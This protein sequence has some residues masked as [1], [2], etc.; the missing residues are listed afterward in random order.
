MNVLD[1]AMQMEVDGQAY[2]Q[3]MAEKTRLPGLKTIFTR[4]ADDEKK[5]YDIFKQLKEGQPTPEMLDTTVLDETQ[6]VFAKLPET[7][8]TLDTTGEDLAAYRHAMQI[9]AQSARLYDDAADKESDS[10][11]RALLKRIAE[12]ERKHFNILDNIHQ[13]VNAPNQYLAWGE[14]SN[15]DEFT[16][17]GRDT[18]S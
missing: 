16:Q 9:E 10:T 4:L 3:Q 13:F 12:E 8:E 5:H 2:Y 6:N 7:S 15:L 18:D 1:Y 14:F 17:F 11:I